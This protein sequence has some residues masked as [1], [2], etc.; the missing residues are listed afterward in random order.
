MQCW[1]ATETINY[2]HDPLLTEDWNVVLLKET[3]PQ[4]LKP[5]I[6]KFRIIRSY[7]DGTI[8]DTL[9]NTHFA[10]NLSHL[11]FLCNCVCI[12]NVL[13]VRFVP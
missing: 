1:T 13:N 12:G 11:E 3:P 6:W 7:N 9:T 8:R 2:W 5:L 10:G 4:S